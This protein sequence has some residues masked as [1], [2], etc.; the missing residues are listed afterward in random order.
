MMQEN[1]WLSP[2]VTFHRTAAPPS[3][4]RISAHP[5]QIVI[6]FPNEQPNGCRRYIVGVS[7]TERSIAI[8]T[9]VQC[10]GLVLRQATVGLV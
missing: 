4:V 9:V 3:V 8:D 6:G 10:E 2:N 5:T 7:N 1:V